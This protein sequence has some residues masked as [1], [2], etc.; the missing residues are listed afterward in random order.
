MRNLYKVMSWNPAIGSGLVTD[1]AYFQ[2]E[3]QTIVVTSADLQDDAYLQGR[4]YAGE[5]ISAEE[6]MNRCADRKLTDILVENGNR[7]IPARMD[8]KPK[9]PVQPAFNPEPPPQPKFR[10]T[11]FPTWSDFEA[12]E[13]RVAK[14]EAQRSGE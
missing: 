12:L 4:L 3:L 9:E 8:L 7:S 5:T 14:L 10:D 6:D 11:M 2:G 1:G 13:R